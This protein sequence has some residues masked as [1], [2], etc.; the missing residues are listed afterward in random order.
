MMPVEEYNSL[1]GGRT[2]TKSI[3]SS[4]ELIS[5]EE[6]HSSPKSILKNISQSAIGKN[7]EIPNSI[8]NDFSHSMDQNP[9][10]EKNQS[11]ESLDDPLIEVDP[12]NR[13]NCFHEVIPLVSEFGLIETQE[14]VCKPFSKGILPS[15]VYLV[16]D[17]SV[18]LEIRCLEE[19][20]EL[21]LVKEEDKARQVLCLFATQRNAKRNCGRNQ[22]VIKIPDSNLFSITIPFLLS[23][24]ITRLLLESTLITIED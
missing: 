13:S 22:R 4:S 7:D 23:R 17:R 3:N 20:P 16:V 2:K 9:S 24:G 5:K 1:K 10:E 12:G 6:D 14:I 19:F 18:E 21:G 11:L 8:Q 15:Q